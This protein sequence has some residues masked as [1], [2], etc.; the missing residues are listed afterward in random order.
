[1][2]LSQNSYPWLLVP[3]LTLLDDRARAFRA[4]RIIWPK[5]WSYPSLAAVRSVGSRTYRSLWTM[6]TTPSSA[7]QSADMKL[8]GRSSFRSRLR[9]NESHPPPLPAALVDRG[10]CGVGQVLSQEEI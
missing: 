9:I 5:I 4:R 10:T 2:P 6:T 3:A 7:A 1:M 8:H